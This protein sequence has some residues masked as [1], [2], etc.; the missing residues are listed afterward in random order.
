MF[1]EQSRKTERVAVVAAPAAVD[2]DSDF[3]AYQARRSAAEVERKAALETVSVHVCIF[4]LLLS[5]IVG[6][7]EII[8]LLLFLYW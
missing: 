5:Q 8:M 1:Q 7:Y 2:E 3:A 4:L 6:I